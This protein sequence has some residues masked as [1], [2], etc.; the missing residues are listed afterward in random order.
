[1]FTEPLL[2]RH[3][4]VQAFNFHRF[5][6]GSERKAYEAHLRHR[7]P[8]FAMTQMKDGKIVPAEPRARHLVVDY[9]E[10]MHGNEA[11]FGLDVSH[12]TELLSALERAV[13]TG[14]VSSTG[15]LTLAQGHG[16]LR[17]FLVIMPVY[18]DG[19]PLNSAEA[20]RKAVIGDTAAVFNA[21]YLVE[22]ILRTNG[23][24]EDASIGISVY[25]AATQDERF[26]AY[27]K[28]SRQVAKATLSW[29]PGW[30]FH[31]QP[32]EIVHNFDVAGRTWRVVVS[33]EP[34]PF[35]RQHDGA[36]NTLVGGILFS[37][38]LAAFVQVLASRS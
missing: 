2:Q 12:N 30:I 10:P 6:A 14:T 23:L 29:V 27:R 3:P 32:E 21:S 9:I 4:Y 1:M 22:Q 18:R 16:D 15:L 7:Y 24:M 28:E 33:A 17:G 36:L 26:L 20:R 8:E 13:D 5:V 25:A 34:Q 31:D 11:A 38:L 19:M 37:M 35:Y